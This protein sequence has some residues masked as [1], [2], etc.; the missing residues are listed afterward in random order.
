M[1]ANNCTVHRDRLAIDFDRV[2]DRQDHPG[3]ED[4]LAQHSLWHQIGEAH[5]DESR[6]RLAASIG[7]NS[8]RFWLGGYCDSEV[9]DRG[10]PPCAAQSKR[11]SIATACR[12]ELC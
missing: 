3:C 8:L 7:D 1:R 4:D 12:G 6:R 2:E 5:P 11:A 10:L 9:D